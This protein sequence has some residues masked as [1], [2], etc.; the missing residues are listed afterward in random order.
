MEL[1]VCNHKRAS[2]RRVPFLG[3]CE[4]IEW[5]AGLTQDGSKSQ[6]IGSQSQEYPLNAS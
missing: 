3:Y 5:A 2:N 4:V 6:M 1:L